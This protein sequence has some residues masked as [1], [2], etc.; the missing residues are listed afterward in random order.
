[1]ELGPWKAPQRA[2]RTDEVQKL[3][4]L[5]VAGKSYSEIAAVLGR[6]EGATQAKAHV[7][8]IRLRKERRENNYRR[9][10]RST[11]WSP[12]DIERLVRCH[13]D[14][15]TVQDMMRATGRTENAVCGRAHAL[16][17]SLAGRDPRK[18]PRNRGP[19][20]C[21]EPMQIPEPKFR[22]WNYEDEQALLR[23]HS[24]GDSFAAIGAALSRTATACKQHLDQMKR[25]TAGAPPTKTKPSTRPC[26]CCGKPF[27]SEGP[28]NRLCPRCRALDVSPYAI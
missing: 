1:M 26:L 4:D 23:R 16:G 28:G 13:R 19:E 3:R 18:L 17:L 25:G 2:W 15:G 7:L 27:R 21:T 10:A 6:G 12:A 8:G 11:D 24:N 9:R 14:G 22:A 5:A 20:S